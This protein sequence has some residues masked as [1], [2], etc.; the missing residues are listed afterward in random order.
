MGYPTNRVM[1]FDKDGNTL[2][3]L[4]P[5]EVFARVRTEEINGPHELTLVTTR[6]LTVGVCVVTVDSTGKWREFVVYKPDEEHQ[7]GK[8][9]IG[10]YQCMWSLQYDLMGVLCTTKAEPGMGFSCTAQVALQAALDG[11]SRWSVG[12]CD[13]GEV[14]PGK[15]CVMIGISAWERLKLVVKHWGGEVDATITVDKSGVVSRAV[16]LRTHLGR[17]DVV[18]RFDWAKD[19]TRIKRIPD[20]GPYYCRVVPLGRGTREYA[21]DDKTEFEWPI[22]IEEETG[23]VPYIEDAEAALVFRRKNP[24]GTW[25]YPTKKVNYDQD[26]PELLLDEATEDLPNHTHPS[27]GYEADVL[28]FADAGM[29][30]HGISLGDDTQ[31]VDRGFNEDAP[32]NI[33]GRVLRLEVDELD[34]KSNT[35]VTLGSLGLTFADTLHEL[36]GT[37]TRDITTSVRRIEKGGTIAYLES[38]LDKINEQINS[39]GGY[40]YLVPGLGAVTYNTAVTDPAVGAEASQVTEIRGGTLRFANS[41]ENGNWK[42]T[43]VITA[44]GYLA[45]AATIARLTSG[46]IGNANGNYWDLDNRQLN[47]AAAATTIDNQ[48]LPQ[49]IGANLGLDQQK[50]FNLLTNNGALQGL[51]MQSGNLYINASYIQTGYLLASL[52]TSGKIQ[53]TNGKVY[54]DLTNDEI[55]SDRL[56]S[57]SNLTALKNLILSFG[58]ITRYSTTKYGLLLTDSTQANY[59]L[60]IIPAADSRLYGINGK[61]ARF[62]SPHGIELET[63]YPGNSYTDAYYQS[64]IY[65]YRRCI[66]MSIFHHQANS[67]ISTTDSGI[68]L[69]RSADS[70]AMTLTA[71]G[72]VLFAC[73]Q[74]TQINWAQYVPTFDSLIASGTKSRVVK[75][76]HYGDRL[77]HAYETPSPLFGDFG[78]ATIGED[79]IC[80]VSIDDVFSE[81]VRTDMAYQVFLQKCGPGD[82]W[83]SDKTPTYFVVEGTPGLLFDWQIT[84]HQKDYE[85]ARIDDADTYKAAEA[86]GKA[87]TD[88]ERVFESDMPDASIED[89][90]QEDLDLIY[91]G[92]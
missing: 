34:P 18:R 10:T 54:F 25:L 7:Q 8:R 71:Y 47:M 12:L 3:D 75:T 17:S 61:V 82:V 30:V 77:L 40:T 38:V 27:V 35:N 90:Y 50:V 39:T 41:R 14:Y 78:S 53:A 58:E 6:R 26:D 85:T 52:I 68:K 59:P 2:G 48:S 63:F 19:L 92:L 13:V 74:G 4:A 1:L 66:D 70:Y 29:D 64:Q 5:A 45:L 32:L 67:G 56:I 44:D 76:E 69:G 11:Q 46:Y 65:M 72:D 60:R 73:S 55:A 57:T 79:G 87:D 24:D 23:G 9:A 21:E 62:D 36:I 43:N 80:I 83:V 22:G 28:Q 20:E 91:A 16:D 33:S 49:Y 31:C 81:T 84:A 89:V 37:S 86:M 51:F 15:G 88:V 42:F